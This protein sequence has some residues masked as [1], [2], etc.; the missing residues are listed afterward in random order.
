MIIT[1]DAS[2]ATGAAGPAALRELCARESGGVHVRLM[3]STHD[4]HLMV[5]VDDKRT[6]EGFQVAVLGHPPLDV[7]RHPFAYAAIRKTR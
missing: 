1:E 4:G 5:S 7:Y 3:W 6:G 2:A